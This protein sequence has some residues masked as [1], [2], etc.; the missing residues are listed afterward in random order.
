MM[1]TL[2]I[3]DLH[4]EESRRDITDAFLAFLQSKA[5]EAEAL[6]ILGDFFESWIGDDEHTPLQVEVLGALKSYT[7]AGHQLFFMH[8]NRDFLIGEG[9][10]AETGATLLHDPCVIDLYG[11]R[12]I[13]LH[14]DS[15]CTRDIGYMN[16]RKN[17]RNPEWQRLFLIRPLQDRRTTAQQLRAISMAKNKGKKEEIMDVT[18]EEV[19]KAMEDQQVTKMIHGHTHRPARHLVTLANGAT[20]ERIVLG[21]WDHSIWYLEAQQNG[22]WQ[23]H[24]KALA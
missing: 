19:I 4:L 8:G 3:S 22:D 9:F 11:D 16:F 15:L 5:R 18:P 17:M 20:A 14:G 24:S 10:A 1:T 7:D 13:L 21:D 2:F 12:V 23:L 6:Y